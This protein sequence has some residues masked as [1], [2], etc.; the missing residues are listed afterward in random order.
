MARRYAAT[1]VPF[2]IGTAGWSI[3]SQ[4]AAAFPGSGTHLARYAA[5]LPAVEINS[6]FYRPHRPA[7]YARW[8]DS[9]P[10]GFRFAVKVPKEITHTL[11]LVGAEAPLARFLSEV[12]HLGP[13]LGPLLLQLPPSFGF[14]AAV[15]SKFLNLLR[16]SF[17]GVLVCE[18]RHPSWFDGTADTLLAAHGIP[19]VAA[20]PPP[21]AAAARPGGWPGLRYW[22]LHGSPR[23]YYSPY[24]PERLARLAALLR[25]SAAE[26]WVIFDNTA[27][28]AAWA[29]ALALL[30]RLGEE[31][32]PPI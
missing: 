31:I 9:V 16:A 27:E 19:R 14:D 30:E 32:H 29:D 1:M 10:D 23:M 28:G 8:A 7:T 26:N 13:K 22:R 6:S 18:P 17:D 15:V 5:Q 20:D 25:D 2:R 4:H 3:P 24:A 12:S 21:V 11:R